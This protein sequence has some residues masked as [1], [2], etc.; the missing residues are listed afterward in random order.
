MT[1]YVKARKAVGKRMYKEGPKNILNDYA[2]MYETLKK[3]NAMLKGLAELRSILP[4][5][6][7]EHVLNMRAFNK[8]LLAKIDGKE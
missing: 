2:E 4:P 1:G 7:R 3:N 6:L 8:K 5:A